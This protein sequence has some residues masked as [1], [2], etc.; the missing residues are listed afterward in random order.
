MFHLNILSKIIFKYLIA[1]PYPAIF[2]A[3]HIFKFLW[4]Q[5]LQHYLHYHVSKDQ[6]L[7]YSLTRS[8]LWSEHHRAQLDFTRSV[9]KDFHKRQLVHSR[10]LIRWWEFQA[11]RYVVWNS[12]DSIRNFLKVHYF[13]YLWTTLNAPPYYIVFWFIIANHSIFSQI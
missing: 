8:S 4:L 7:I 1:N 10:K 13:L 6:K 5:F 3:K 2:W 9:V 11:Q 12:S